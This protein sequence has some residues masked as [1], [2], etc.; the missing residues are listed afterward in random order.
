L[1]VEWVYAFPLREWERATVPHKSSLVKNNQQ[2]TPQTFQ[3]Q[4][5]AEDVVNLHY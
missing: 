5:V 1:K 3:Q 2:P 4:A